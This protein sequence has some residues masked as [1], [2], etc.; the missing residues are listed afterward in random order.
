MGAPGADHLSDYITLARLY[1]PRVERTQISLTPR[2]A[3]RL[4]QLA[5]HRGTSMASLIRDAVERVYPEP[6]DRE[7]P[8]D[9]ALLSVGR[10][11]SGRT[12]VSADHDRALPDAFGE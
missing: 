6:R 12:D 5:R 9:R 2:Q 1:H 7:D 3:R 11:R 10:F 4:R 8:W